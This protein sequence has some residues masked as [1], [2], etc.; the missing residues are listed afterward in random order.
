MFF[1][2]L[3][4]SLFHQLNGE[5]SVMAPYY[6]LR[7]KKSGQTLQDIHYYKVA[8]FFGVGQDLSKESYN[9]YVQE[10][11]DLKWIH[12]IEKPIVTDEGKE[13][14]DE[15]ST[16][17]HRGVVP[18]AL[19]SVEA[20]LL[21]IA[22]LASNALYENNR[23][24]PVIDN[25]TIQHRVKEWLYTQP[26]L[27]SVANEV[28]KT[29]HS[30]VTEE[31][32]TEL[33]KNLFVYRITGYETAGLTWTQLAEQFNTAA[34]DCLYVY[35]Q[36]VLRFYGYLEQQSSP[37]VRLF[38]P[39]SPLTETAKNTQSLL[40]KGYSVEEVSM[41]RNLKL[42]TIEDHIIELASYTTSF[43]YQDYI[44]EHD[45]MKIKKMQ[46]QLN[47]HKLKLLREQ[48]PQFSYFQIRLALALG[49]NLNE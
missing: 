42:S 49:G 8:G 39:P 43:N 30:F 12:S 47:T 41:V 27:S 48:L 23:Y 18:P 37:L 44:S 22:Q 15:F 21:L 9:Q 28:K 5:R 7:G 31:L 38:E 29:L 2:K 25:Q 40:K 10:L 19:L 36:S 34:I 26:S 33:E 1:H 46:S 45:V 16:L 3:L 11:I 14:L 6:I 35:R 20:T 13:Q 4:T 32:S 24:I 17:F